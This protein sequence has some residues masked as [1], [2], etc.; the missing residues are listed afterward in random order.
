MKMSVLMNCMI[1]LIC[2]FMYRRGITNSTDFIL[3]VCDILIDI[4][5]VDIYNKLYETSTS[6]VLRTAKRNQTI[7]NM[8]DIRGINTS[9]HSLQS[10]QNVLINILPKY[11]YDGNLVHLNYKSILRNTGFQVLDIEYEFSFVSLSS[12]RRDEDL[13]SEMDKYE[14]FLEKAD[15]ALLIQFQ[16]ACDDAMNQIKLMYGPFDQDEIQY[17]K[18]RLSNGT[19]CTINSFQRDLIFNLFYRYFVDPVTLNFINLD[20]YIVLLIAAKR[21]LE[22]WGMHMLSYIISSKVVRLASR[23]NVNKKESTKLESSPL[24]EKIKEKYRWNEKIEKHILSIIAAILSSE[25]EIIEPEDPELDGQRISI[26]PEIICEEML[27]Y[28]SLID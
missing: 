22:T 1:P 18:H 20:D 23:K 19:K 26:I 6:N 15:E 27:L 10:V 5:D 2:H 12:S 11:R 3:S 13:N 28:I 17:Y 16:V 25:F 24:Y 9:I 14:S 8:Q 4:Y 7:W 21:I